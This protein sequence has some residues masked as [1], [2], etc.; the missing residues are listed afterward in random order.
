MPERRLL[1]LLVAASL[2]GGAL[3]GACGDDSSGGGAEVAL[4]AAG[5]RGQQVADD[6]GCFSCHST[7]GSKGTGPTW[8]GLYGS[9]VE[10][11][12]GE[13]VTADDA[14]LTTAILQARDE[15]VEGYAN[16]MPVYD[17]KLTDAEVADLIAYLQDLAPEPTEG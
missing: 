2:A 13:T 7:D 10:L 12:G 14:Y 8:E 1:A 17:G 6:N 5:E 16:I 11:K 4:S 3:L 15:T 9:E